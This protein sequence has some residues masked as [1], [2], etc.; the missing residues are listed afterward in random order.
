MD[1]EKEIDAMEVRG[2]SEGREE[3]NRRTLVRYSRI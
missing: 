1:E 3:E 2:D